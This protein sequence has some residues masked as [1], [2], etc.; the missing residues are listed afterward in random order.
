MKENKKALTPEEK[1]ERKV[2][3]HYTIVNHSK[4]VTTILSILLGVCAILVG[5]GMYILSSIEGNRGT[6]D[7]SMGAIDIIGILMI[8]TG[9]V[10]LVTL[11]LNIFHRKSLSVI[12]IGIAIFDVA[13]VLM[14]IKP[15]LESI[16]TAGLVVIFV[17]CLLLW[18]TESIRDKKVCNKKFNMRADFMVEVFSQEDV[19]AKFGALRT[20]AN[21]ETTY[22][23]N[24]YYI[25]SILFTYLVGIGLLLPFGKRAYLYNKGLACWNANADHKE[26]PDVN[27]ETL[28]DVPFELFLDCGVFH[29][30]GQEFKVDETP[31]FKLCRD[32]A[33]V[34]RRMGIIYIWITVAL[35]KITF[36]K[37]FNQKDK[38]SGG[39]LV[40]SNNELT[41]TNAAFAQM[42]EDFRKQEKEE[43]YQDSMAAADKQIAV[44]DA[45]ADLLGGSSTTTIDADDDEI[46]RARYGARD[47][48]ISSDGTNY[49]VEGDAGNGYAKTKLATYNK[50]TGVGT[51]KDSMGNTVTV[52]NKN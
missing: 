52:R 24:I 19:E 39:V 37:T 14:F 50:T 11:A 5:T 32:R 49:Y 9:F 22:K 10:G 23:A 12:S 25:L 26:K 6:S 28:K 51:Y 33:K 31:E 2:A 40:Y 4:K 8:L 41:K 20:A 38:Q 30:G 42:L 35:R 17:G 46:E 1:A 48:T 27:P 18:I 7:G 45:I 16:A 13:I 47:A 36:R 15:A 34:S 44:C 43:A 29:L 3:K 21:F